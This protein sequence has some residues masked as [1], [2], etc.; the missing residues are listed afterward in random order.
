MSTRCAFGIEAASCYLPQPRV[1]ID[2]WAAA[3]PVA[4][5]D[6]PA[7]RVAGKHHFHQAGEE[8]VEDMAVKALQTLCNKHSIDPDEVDLLVFVHSMQ[9]SAPPAPASLPARLLSRFGLR[10][11]C[12]FAMAGQNCASLLVAIRVIR[13]LFVAEPRMGKVLLVSADRSCGEAYRHAGVFSFESDGASAMLLSRH[14]PGNRVLGILGH[15]DGRH[16]GGLRRPQALVRDYRALYGTLAHKLVARTAHAFAM[17]LRDFRFLVPINID[18]HILEQLCRSLGMPP[19]WAF[20]VNIAKHGHVMCSDVILN[21]L[22]LL[23]HPALRPGDKLL[24]FMSGNNGA[25]ATMALVD[26]DQF[27]KPCTNP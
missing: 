8:S 15:V 18:R 14:S 12:C 25:F 17:E 20:T 6:L 3:N 22:D 27:H 13:T 16:H 21:F 2:A 26:C 5:Q 24:F 11:A 1:T 23:K 9:T 4:A 10:K 7:S 19:S